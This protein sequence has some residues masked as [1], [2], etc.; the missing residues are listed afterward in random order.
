MTGQV[1][2]SKQ[3]GYLTLALDDNGFPVGNI[4]DDLMKRFTAGWTEIAE[5]C[6]KEVFELIHKRRARI[7]KIAAILVEEESMLGDRFRE[8][9]K[10]FESLDTDTEVETKTVA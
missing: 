2:M 4:G 9:W 7:R 10:Q 6:R 1:G 5:T 3:L 8:L